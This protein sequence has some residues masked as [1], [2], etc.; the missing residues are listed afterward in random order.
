M[1]ELTILFAD[2]DLHIRLLMQHVFESMEVPG[3]EDLVINVTVVEDGDVAVEK[4]REQR[5][6]ILF[7]DIR[8]PK[9]NG[10]DAVREIRRIQ[11]DI[12]VVFATAY[13]EKNMDAI[14]GLKDHVMK[15]PYN[16]THVQDALLEYFKRTDPP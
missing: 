7:S 16:Y 11:A 9:M 3:L 5:Y 1:P 2:D 6:D 15:K 12:Y 4:V 13:V 14:E 8:M 10:I